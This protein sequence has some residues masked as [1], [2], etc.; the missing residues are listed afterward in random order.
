M[1]GPPTTP[2]HVA[3]SS[4]ASSDQY[5]EEIVDVLNWVLDTMPWGPLVTPVTTTTQ[6]DTAAGPTDVGLS[7]TFTQ[8]TGRRMRT[9]LRCLYKGVNGDEKL[10]FTLCDGSNNIIK[11][12][13]LVVVG[14]NSGT[15]GEFSHDESPAG[16]STTRK[17]R[18]TKVAG[19]GLVSMVADATNFAQLS[20]EDIGSA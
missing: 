4:D 17:I 2:S 14:A 10:T 12:F 18:I 1:A 11:T 20:V 6:V 5:N 16:G 15:Y 9:T 19:T 13:A 3:A 8:T 7:L